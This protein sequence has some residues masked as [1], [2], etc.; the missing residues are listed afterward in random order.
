VRCYEPPA[1]SHRVRSD[2]LDTERGGTWQHLGQAS[3]D[4]WAESRF[5]QATRILSSSGAHVVLLTTPYYQS[6]AQSDGQP[7]PENE[8]SRVAID[9]RLLD[10]AAATDP[11]AATVVDLGTML[12][13][14]GQFSTLVD[15]V[16]VRCSDGIH[17]T[18]PGG[19]WVGEHLLPRLVALG[20]PHAA[21]ASLEKRPPLSPQ[22]PPAWYTKLPCRA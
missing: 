2:T 3:F 21:T 4:G 9:N 6:G 7:L 12:S 20:Q 18:V 10:K 5:E 15:G 19:Q 22:I 16:P 8:P 14:S 1:D 11:G 13:P 17:L